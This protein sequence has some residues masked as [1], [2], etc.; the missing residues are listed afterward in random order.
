MGVRT[1]SCV[2]HVFDVMSRRVMVRGFFGACNQRE[3]WQP[4]G[5][6]VAIVAGVL[7]E[8]K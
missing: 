1:V 8:V 2:S 7:E 5:E 4:K 6:K 3:G